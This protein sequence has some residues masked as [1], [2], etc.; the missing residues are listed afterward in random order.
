MDPRGGGEDAAMVRTERRWWGRSGGRG[1]RGGC[2]D[3]DEAAP[4]GHEEQKTGGADREGG[5]GSDE[6]GG[7]VVDRDLRWLLYVCVGVL[8][9]VWSKMDRGAYGRA[10]R[11]LWGIGKGR[12][13]PR[14]RFAMARGPTKFG[15][16]I[17]YV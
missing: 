13:L 10:K 2:M 15:A 11:V 1:E 6:W 3:T 5:W 14:K 7:S 17:R 16:H 9:W 4:R 8:C 12:L